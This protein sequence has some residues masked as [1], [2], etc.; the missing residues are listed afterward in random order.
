MEAAIIAASR[1]HNYTLVEKSDR[2]GGN[3]HPAGAPYFK[4]DILDFCKVL[5]KRIDEAGVRVVLNTEV[6]EILLNSFHR[7]HCS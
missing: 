2:L 6:T 5:E 4:K 1:G 7:M 3:L